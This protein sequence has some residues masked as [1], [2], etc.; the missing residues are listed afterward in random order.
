VQGLVP[1][2]FNK[3]CKE[4]ADKT[5]QWI[6]F[7]G[8]VD[9]LWIESMNSVLDDSKKLCLP[10][11]EIIDITDYMSCMFETDDL[12]EASPA[13]ISRCGMVYMDPKALGTTCFFVNFTPHLPLKLQET[14][15]DR[16]MKL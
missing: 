9:S 7:D 15:A 10:S 2:I 1:V 3:S 11:S 6:M 14:F 16:L 12:S 8:P 5:K 4:V 13:T